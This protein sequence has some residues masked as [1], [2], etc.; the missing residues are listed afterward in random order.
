[1]KIEITKSQEF[2]PEIIDVWHDKPESIADFQKVAEKWAR[3]LITD[4]IADAIKC[5]KYLDYDTIEMSVSVSI[6]NPSEESDN[7]NP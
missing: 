3:E 7:E 4:A 1:M 5:K 2:R 6:G